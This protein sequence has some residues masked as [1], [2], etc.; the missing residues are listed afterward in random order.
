MSWLPVPHLQQDKPAWCLPACAAMV[1]AYWKQP[2]YQADIARWL[3]TTPIGTP[4]SR[5]QKI[6]RHGFDVVYQTGSWAQLVE[7][8]E[9]QVPCIVFVR[10]GELPYWAVDTPHAVVLAGIATE[11]VFLFD[12]AFSEAP[13]EAPVDAF[14]LAWSYSDYTYAVISPQS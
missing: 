4:S 11:S 1:A 9:Q 13:L 2:L 14:M 8:L 7:W 10:T 12:P 6:S 3:G 5:I